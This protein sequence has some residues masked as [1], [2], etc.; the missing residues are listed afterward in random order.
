MSDYS[1]DFQRILDEELGNY[2]ARAL[3]ELAAA[4]Q[5]QGLVLT[6]ELLQSLRSEVVAASVRHV[7]SMGIAFEQYGRIRDMKGI[8]RSAAPP[9]AEIEDYVKKVGI[10][11]FDYVPG[12]RHGQFPLTK[13]VAINRIAWGIARARLRDNSQVRPKAW[14]AKTFYSS[15]NRFIDAVTTRYA[16]QTGTHIAASIRI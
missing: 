16:A 3:A 10:D 8:N 11:K 13:A 1:A 15:I 2:A 7:A 6:E 4:I 14:F 9:L 5:K 12:Y